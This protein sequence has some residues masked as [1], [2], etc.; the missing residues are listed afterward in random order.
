MVETGI[1]QAFAGQNVA[2]AG[3]EIWNSADSGI[4]AY[5]AETGISFPVGRNGWS[6]DNTYSVLA[7]SIVVIDQSGVVR[8]V[9]QLGTST[10]TYTRMNQMVDSAAATVRN[11]LGS[12]AVVQP[13][14]AALPAAGRDSHPGGCFT[15]A[16]RVALKAAKAPATQMRVVR[17]PR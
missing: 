17:E 11:L 12:G 8:F 16:G 15:L 13:A 3:V 6:V 10:V 7:N 9:D 14:L 5:I 1:V 4:A 2:V